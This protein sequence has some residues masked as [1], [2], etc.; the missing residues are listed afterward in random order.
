MGDQMGSYMVGS[1]SHALLMDQNLV[2]LL[3][4]P[5]PLKEQV[6]CEQK[7]FT[8]SLEWEELFRSV[9]STEKYC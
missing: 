2:L 3:L 8:Y 4:T 6:I 5:Y 9:S 1:L 7:I